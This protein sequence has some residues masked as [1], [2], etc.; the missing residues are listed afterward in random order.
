MAVK[1]SKAVL[2]VALILPCLSACGQSDS[3]R[4]INRSDP[5]AEAKNTEARINTSDGYGL[6]FACSKSGY[7]LTFLTPEVQTWQQRPAYIPL[8][9]KDLTYK[10]QMRIDDA[11]VAEMTAKTRWTPPPSDRLMY[12]HDQGDGLAIMRAA[13]SAKTRV[14][15]GAEP[16]LRNGRRHVKEF[17]VT[18]AKEAISTTL[19]AC[20]LDEKKG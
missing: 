7:G 9:G 3:D 20:G 4:W 12:D 8:D 18:G 13:M 1:V 15:V 2:F 19:A 10:F 14:V 16:N 5:L 17:P 6:I 11:P